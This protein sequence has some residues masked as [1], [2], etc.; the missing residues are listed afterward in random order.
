MHKYRT[1]N[2]SILQSSNVEEKVKLTGWVHRKRNHGNLLFI[3]LRDFYGYTQC[4]I[5]ADNQF[6]KEL[7]HASSESIITIVGTVSKRDENNINTELSTGEIEVLITTASI[8]S[9]CKELPLEV[10]GQTDYPEE[11]RLKYRYLDIRREKVKKNLVLR[12]GIISA[13]RKEM[14][15]QGFIEIQT[16]I[17]TSSSPEGARDFV[18]PSRRFPGKFYA[19]PQ[20]PEQ[21]KQLLMVGGI[22][23]YFQIAPSFRDEDA[24]ADRSPGEFYQLDFEM[25]FCTQEDVFTLS[26]P[27][28]YNVFK[29]FSNEKIKITPPSFPRITYDDALLKYG[30]D[31]PDLRNPLIM[32]ELTEEFKDSDFTVFSDMIKNKGSIVRGIR[33][34]KAASQ[35]RKFFDKLNSFAIDEGM[36][37]LA[38][39][40]YKENTS[41]GPLVKHLNEFELKTLKDKSSSI[42]G[43]VLFLICNEKKK[44]EKFGFQVRTKIAEELD[45]IEKD[46]FRFCWVIDFP[47][48]EEDEETGKIVFSHN[49][50]SMPQGEL[51]ALENEDPLTIKA[52]QY[53]IVCNG[54]ELSSGAIRNHLPDVMI[55]AFEIAGYNEDVIKS[56]FGA[57]YNAFQYGAPPHG[58]CAPGIDRIVMLL[59]NEANIREVIPFPMNQKAQDLMMNAPSE[60]EDSQI[61]ELHIRP[62]KNV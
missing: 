19:L 26:E 52:Y 9:K 45:L 4:V 51:K 37:G 18:V 33:V 7:T 50:F 58:G 46:A 61:K 41:K 27:V 21:F 49:P 17:L 30:I 35:S 14:E 28:L 13:L 22:D 36:G 12:S 29:K 62:I 59:A 31:K 60:I 1:H 42:E 2:C 8:E 39:I 40:T 47:M 3:D 44:V 32:V 48:F 55:K 11:T 38:Y 5:Q 24:R 56:K 53:D 6:F 54:V 15:N 25:A 57:L 23:K 10:F 20:A 43:D 34:P 16:P